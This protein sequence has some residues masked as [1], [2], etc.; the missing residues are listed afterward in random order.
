MEPY[1]EEDTGP[2]GDTTVEPA[3]PAEQDYLVTVTWEH[4]AQVPTR[5]ESPEHAQEIARSQAGAWRTVAWA[6]VGEPVVGEA[7]PVYGA[8]ETAGAVA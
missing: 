2:S 5:A 7:V 3:E 1:R 4:A 6:P 8:S